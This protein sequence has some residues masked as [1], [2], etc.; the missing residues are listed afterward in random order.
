MKCIIR[1]TIHCLDG[2]FDKF[3]CFNNDEFCTDKHVMF[4][5]VCLFYFICIAEFRVFNRAKDR[6]VSAGDR[7]QI[8]GIDG[9]QNKQSE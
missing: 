9:T 4:Q 3:V 8:V 1:F 6:I 2:I 5:F 7:K